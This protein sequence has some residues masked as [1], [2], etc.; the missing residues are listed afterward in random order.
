MSQR[1]SRLLSQQLS[2]NVLSHGKRRS[3]LNAVEP[4]LLSAGQVV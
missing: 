1:Q 4:S 3:Y 2:A